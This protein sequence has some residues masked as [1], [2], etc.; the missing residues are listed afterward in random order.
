METKK[1][2]YYQGLSGDIKIRYDEKMLKCSGI[3]P[4]MLKEKELSNNRTDFPEINLLDITNH[5]I[6]SVSPFTKKQF[7]NYKGMEAYSFFES[8][9]VLKIGSKKLDDTAILSGK[10]RL[11]KFLLK[12]ILSL[13]SSER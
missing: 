2:M 9:F 12:L 7:K 8:G 5:M 10:V 4:Y 11:E 1:S 6:H 13:K 3:D